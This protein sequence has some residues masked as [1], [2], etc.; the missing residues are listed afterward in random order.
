ME[1]VKKTELTPLSNHLNS[2]KSS[3]IEV[4]FLEIQAR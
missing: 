4:N 1:H 3:L 2:T